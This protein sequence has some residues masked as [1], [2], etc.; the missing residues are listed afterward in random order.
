[1]GTNLYHKFVGT[2]SDTNRVRFASTSIP[3]CPEVVTSKVV[4][5]LDV[6]YTLLYSLSL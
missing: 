1:M 4:L 3:G 6:S 5:V 2:S